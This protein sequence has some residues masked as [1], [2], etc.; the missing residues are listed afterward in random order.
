MVIRARFQNG[1][2]VPE[3]DVEIPDG[4]VVAIVLQGHA[5][6]AIV[7]VPPELQGEFEFWERLGADGWEKFL[8]WEREAS[9]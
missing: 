8:E 1:V 3:S 6:G 5:E 7:Q 9:A 2:A 4:T